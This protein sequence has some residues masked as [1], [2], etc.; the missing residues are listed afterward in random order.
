[1]RASLYVRT[2]CLVLGP[3]DHAAVRGTK[4]SAELHGL[5]HSV[6]AEDE[7]RARLAFVPAPGDEGVLEED[8]G[9]LRVEACTAAH[10]RWAKASGA[11]LRTRPRVTELDMGGG[12]VRATFEGGKLLTV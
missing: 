5:P 9:F 7:V 10:A 1:E 12:K 3:R 2:G 8:A 6:L 4:A 11:T